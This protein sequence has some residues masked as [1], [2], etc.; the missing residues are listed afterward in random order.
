MKRQI[1][2][3]ILLALVSLVIATP[4]T[5]G[6][7]IFGAKTGTVVVNDSNVKTHP[8]NIGVM[9]GYEQGFVIGDLAIEAEVTKTTSKGEIEAGGGK[10]E[11]D[12]KALYLAFRTAGPFYFKAKGGYLESDIDGQTDSGAA[13]GVGLGFGLGIVQFELEVT[14]AA[15]DPADL[16]FVSLGV[17]F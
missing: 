4:A 8:T 5:A 12:T 16:T 7:W 15:V 9:V 3:Y 6:E 2:L 10:F 14:K 13:Y 1:K 11:V 17:Q